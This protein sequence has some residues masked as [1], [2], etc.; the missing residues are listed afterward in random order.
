MVWNNKQSVQQMWGHVEGIRT[1]GVELQTRG[2]PLSVLDVLLLLLHHQQTVKDEHRRSE[3]KKL[4]DSFTK[5]MTLS[6]AHT[7]KN[8][9]HQ[10]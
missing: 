8:I 4:W 7:Q 10:V 2:N 6:Q 3:N 1:R 9:E 5:L